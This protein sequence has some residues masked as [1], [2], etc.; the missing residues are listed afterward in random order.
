M[1]WRLYSLDY[2]E[3]LSV[4]CIGD[5]D[6]IATQ[7]VGLPQALILQNLNNEIR[8]IVP[9]PPP[10]RPK[11]KTVPFTTDIVL[12]RHSEKWLRMKRRYM[13]YDLHLSETMIST[14]TVPQT[15]Y[16]VLSRILAR[17]YELTVPLLRSLRTDVPFS[18]DSVRMLDLIMGI[19]DTHPNAISVI[20]PSIAGMQQRTIKGY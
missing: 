20:F 11:I 9:T 15:L 6:S 12:D 7:L 2:S 1:K 10:V 3:F 8:F 18:A 14:D 13:I 4:M 5:R 19:E 17:E 16:L